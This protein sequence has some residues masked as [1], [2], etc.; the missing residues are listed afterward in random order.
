MKP[1]PPRPPPPPPPPVVGKPKAAQSQ[2][3][4]KV[5]AKDS[6]STWVI[7]EVVQEIANS[8]EVGVPNGTV[9]TVASKDI[10]EVNPSVT[11]DMTALRYL[12]E[13]GILVN[14][15]E[16]YADRKIYTYMASALL[17]V[18]PFT[19]IPHP[20][21]TDYVAGNGANN[22][23]H[24]YAIAENC[25]RN[26][27]VL[28]KNQSVVISGESGA[29]KTETAK[30]I[31]KYLAERNRAVASTS[32]NAPKR[33]TSISG[34][35]L[36]HK[37]NRVSPILESFGNA[38]TTRNH[39]SSRFGKFMKLN[40]LFNEQSSKK[41]SKSMQLTGAMI[42]TYLLEKSR[43]VFQS[44]QERNFHIFYALLQAP[45]QQL[46]ASA[47]LKSQAFRIA[48]AHSSM[49]L[50]ETHTLQSVTEALRTIGISDSVIDE[51]WQIL[52]ALLF[53]CEV[54]FTEKETGEGPVAAIQNDA[55]VQTTAKLLGVNAD[56][57]RYLVTQREVTA[58]GEKF[59]VPLTLRE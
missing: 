28:R 34:D 41:Q 17:A 35:E 53:L 49:T 4:R 6:T 12:H 25:Y 47:N 42:E 1:N 26:L 33:R 10:F 30:I 38:K 8:V 39:N 27:L 16:R 59:N 55:H 57:V 19:S 14:L 29:G 21:M 37:L 22:P 54:S 18:N 3:R 7:G 50:E 2:S 43:V 20:S 11:D 9:V 36:Y 23:P 32:A 15:K 44:D 52:T 5:W 45:P 48:K 58:R 46:A 51:I 24:P 56:A 31:V 13:P 40:F